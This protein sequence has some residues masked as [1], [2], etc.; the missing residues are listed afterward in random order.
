M[1][2]KINLGVNIDHVATLRNARGENDPSLLEMAMCAQNAGADLI[3]VHLREDRRHVRDA[4]VFELKKH[5]KIPINFEMALSDEILST[6]LELK[7]YSVCIVPEKREE[8]TT[9]GGLDAVQ[10]KN[11]IAEYSEK[12]FNHGIQTYLFIE[13]EEKMV[14][15]AKEAHVSGVEFHT[16][17]FARAF[18]IAKERDKEIERLR[19]ASS[20]AH[21]ESLEVH[22]G[23]GINYFNASY[24]LP[25]LEISEFN[26]GHAIISRSIAVGLNQ[27]IYEMKKILDCNA[28]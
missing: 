16:G 9:E 14:R 22:A 15:A 23:H 24:L 18:L 11:K 10:Y 25:I 4:D 28:V 5:L 7:P 12:L 13:P 19:M 6:V 8:V 20:F 21:K 17:S 2:R 1:K 26:I 3:T 27:A